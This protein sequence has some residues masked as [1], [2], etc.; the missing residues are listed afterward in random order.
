MMMFAV[1]LTVEAY[2]HMGYSTDTVDTVQYNVVTYI[3][4]RILQ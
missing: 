2:I 4:A 1:Q 3:P